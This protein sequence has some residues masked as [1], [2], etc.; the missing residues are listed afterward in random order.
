MAQNFCASLSFLVEQDDIW[1]EYISIYITKFDLFGKGHTIDYND[2][3]SRRDGEVHF[4]GLTEI[5]VNTAVKEESTED[6]TD[7]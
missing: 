5:Y 1:K 3:V 7:N 4:S 6:L 2:R